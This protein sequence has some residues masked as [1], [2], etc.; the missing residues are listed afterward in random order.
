MTPFGLMPHVDYSQLSG[1]SAL[2]Y[3]RI[4]DDDPY[5]YAAGDVVVIL[6]PDGDGVP[7]VSLPIQSGYGVVNTPPWTALR[8]DPRPFAQSSTGVIVSTSVGQ[9][10]MLSM[11]PRVIPP[12]PHASPEHVWVLKATG[13]RIADVVGDSTT[14][15]R[16]EVPQA[17]TSRYDVTALQ[18]GA[19][20]I[21]S[22]EMSASLVYASPPPLV[23]R[24]G[25]ALSGEFQLTN[26]WQ[27]GSGNVI[28]LAPGQKLAPGALYR[29]R[30]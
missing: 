26:G 1:S 30:W 9:A 3:C 11:T 22:G 23:G 25:L 16:G 13:G 8:A 7:V 24:S 17:P 27:G 2:V 15:R 4:A 5:P 14:P 19:S 28:G 10:D 29:V 12:G 21:D 20:L 6:A 18:I